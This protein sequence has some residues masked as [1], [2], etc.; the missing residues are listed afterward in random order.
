MIGDIIVD[1]RITFTKLGETIT[2]PFG[3]GDVAIKLGTK[4]KY[5]LSGRAE[6]TLTDQVLPTG[7]LTNIGLVGIR[8]I[9]TALI[10]TPAAP[11]V[12]A[13]NPGAAQFGYKIVAVQADGHYTAA[14]PQTGVGGT[15]PLSTT[16][17]NIISW[18][19]IEEAV[20]YDVYRTVGGPSLGKIATIQAPTLY[21]FDTGLVGNGVLPAA[22]SPYDYQILIGD[23]AT[24]YQFRAKGADMF[25]FRWNAGMS[26]HYKAAVTVSDFTYLLIEN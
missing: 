10:E 1:G 18:S 16:Q 4:G 19:A 26:I 24:T 25:I 5:A 21:M 8:N 9:G 6:A 11:V 13:T 22:V 20:S 2:A 7:R 12:T 23:T 15:S 3:I 14:S 17:F